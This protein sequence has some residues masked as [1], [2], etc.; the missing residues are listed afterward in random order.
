[1]Y[2]NPARKGPNR[3]WNAYRNLRV[4][5]ELFDEVKKYM[6]QRKYEYLQN[7]EGLDETFPG[8]LE[9]SNEFLSSMS[10]E[11]QSL[12][13]TMLKRIIREEFENF[14]DSSINSSG[15]KSFEDLTPRKL[16]SK[17]RVME[18]LENH[19]NQE[20][21][22]LQIEELLG[23]PGPTCRQA[24]REIADENSNVI[25]LPGRPNRFKFIPN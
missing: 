21:T 8:S 24:A 20:L 7:R 13:T 9:T 12:T 25:K 18:V 11:V 17:E 14:K 1:M 19:P 6:E 5:E 16:T 15:T 10:P 22:T 23:I 4:P 3:V 2:K